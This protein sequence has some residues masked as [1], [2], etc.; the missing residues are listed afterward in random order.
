MNQTASMR[1]WDLPLRIFHW[2]L[3]VAVLGAVGSSKAGVMWAHE[4]FGLTVMGLVLFRL[5]WGFVGGHYARFANFVKGPHAVLNWVRGGDHRGARAAGHS[6]LAAYSVLALLV[7]M[8]FMA[9]S[10]SMSNDDILFDGP[11]AHLVP[12]LS[13]DVTRLHHF[14]Q[15]LVFVIVGLHI[16]AILFYKFVK[17]H[18]LTATMVHRCADQNA[19]KIIGPDGHI[20][21]GHTLFGL[22]LLL[23]CVGAA[24]LLPFL[25]PGL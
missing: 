19:G 10:G 16:L 12:H 14:G 20:S 7:V 11:L 13:G 22:M 2:G 8:G 23:G 3:L 9:V 15:I 21:R 24:Q 18:P 5:I 25:R 1:I 17:K 4:R 6:P